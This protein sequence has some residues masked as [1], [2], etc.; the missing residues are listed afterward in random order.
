MTLTHQ[1]YLSMFGDILVSSKECR[2]RRGD[3]EEVARIGRKGKLVC[4][5]ECAFDPWREVA[6]AG[7]RVGRGLA[8][9]T[10][11]TRLIWRVGLTTQWRGEDAQGI[12]NVESTSFGHLVR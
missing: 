1:G 8:A 5:A 4:E 10:I 6:K 9:E 12:A 3:N 7:S 2:G 11:L